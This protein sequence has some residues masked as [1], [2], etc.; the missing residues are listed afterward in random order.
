LAIIEGKIMFDSVEGVAPHIWLSYNKPDPEMFASKSVITQIDN[1]EFYVFKY[2]KRHD[3][4]LDIISSHR[5]TSVLFPVY[6]IRL[7]EVYFVCRGN[8]FNWQV[9]VESMDGVI[10]NPIGL[11]DAAVCTIPQLCEGFRDEWVFRA[12]TI[13]PKQYTCTLDGILSLN[14][15]LFL[16]HQAI[17]LTNH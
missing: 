14:N 3:A 1:L 13:N 12:F 6:R 16:Y 17:T 15:L 4:K 8:N 7:G 9:S 10:I 2:A 5:C 11:F